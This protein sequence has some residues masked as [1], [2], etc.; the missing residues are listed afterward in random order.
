[1]LSGKMVSARFE[2]AVAIAG[3]VIIVAVRCAE[4]AQ[5]ENDDITAEPDLQ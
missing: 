5:L 4:G 1:M 3:N 2:D